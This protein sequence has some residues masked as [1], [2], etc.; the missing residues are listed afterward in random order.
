MGFLAQN[1]ELQG[2]LSCQAEARVAE[3]DQ[4]GQNAAALNC[5]LTHNHGTTRRRGYFGWIELAAA[6]SAM[7]Q[8]VN[9]YP[10]MAKAPSTKPF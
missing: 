2:P 9:T 3:E 4:R 5:Y 7:R 1:A 8:V 10:P 6:G